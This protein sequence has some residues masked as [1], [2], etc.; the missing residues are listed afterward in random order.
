MKITFVVPELNLTGGLRV[1]SIYAE[2]LS[3][4]GHLVTVVSANKK[5]PTLK[6]KIKSV[7]KWKGYQFKSGFDRSF[8][9]NS[10]F[11]IKIINSHRAI[12][13]KDVPDADIIIATFWNTAEWISD[14]SKSKGQKIY[15]IQ[16][17]E[18][19][20]WLPLERVK[21]TFSLPYKKIVVSQWIADVLLTKHKIDDV[22]VVPNGV[23]TKQFNSSERTKQE[24]TTFGVMYSQRLYKGCHI[25]FS[26]YEKAKAKNKYMRLV[27]FGTDEPDVKLP[28]PLGTK[29]FRLPKQEELKSIYGQCDAWIFSSTTE[30]FGLPIL[31]AMACRTPVI[32]T[33]CGAAEMLINTSN[34][35]LIDVD[36]V[37]TMS[38]AMSIVHNMNN[39][40]WQSYSN[41]AYSTALKHKWSDTLI[42]FENVLMQV[43]K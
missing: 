11:E 2:L 16:H 34:G 33:N 7:L 13:E 41:L 36:D 18:M 32:A 14:F 24:I 17:Y 30:G 20:S 10:N 38:E 28:L 35:F 19:H 42:Q 39:S 4:R 1:V 9:N 21:A 29:Y 3:N 8:F 37:D 6:E 27:A 23:D 5:L 31:E 40:D 26:A 15:F 12:T 25:A 22:A 43:F